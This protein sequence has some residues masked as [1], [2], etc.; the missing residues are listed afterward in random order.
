MKTCSICK[1]EKDIELFSP[2]SD[3]VGK[4][5]SACKECR[6][7]FYREQRPLS[8]R[9]KHKTKNDSL[10]YHKAKRNKRTSLA[11]ICQEDEFNL[12]VIEEAHALRNL[13]NKITNTTWH[14]DHIIPLQ[15]KY[16]CGLHLWTNLQVIT[17]KENWSKN[18]AFYD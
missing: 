2:R 17:A 3:R 12:F 14:V 13:R 5:L 9:L 10:R 7:Y 4:Y 11:F 18:N 16:V 8:T 15:N 6:N 1:I